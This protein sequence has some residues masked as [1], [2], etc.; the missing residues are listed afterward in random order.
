MTEAGPAPSVAATLRLAARLCRRDL[1]SAP[2]LVIVLA[3]LVAVAAITAVGAFTDRVRLALDAQA[4]ALLAGDLALMSSEPLPAAARDAA[5]AAG[6]ASSEILAM[7]SV[8]AHGKDLQLIELKAVGAGY[9]LR[10]ELL[11]GDA[12]FAPGH[13]AGGIPPRGEAWVEPRLL[14]RL[15][16]A[17]GDELAIGEAR[18]RA[19]KLVLLEPDRAGSFFAI[20]PRVLM[21]LA[22]LPATGLIAPG[23]R[24]QHGLLV[25]GERAAVARF[26]HTVE[27]GPHARWQTP[28]DARPEIRAAMTHAS[29]FLGLAT[30]VATTLSGV[31]I[32]L[33]ARS[34]ARARFDGIALLRTLG[35]TRAQLAWLLGGEFL[36]LG[37]LAAALGTIAG[38]LLQ[39]VLAG[40]LADWTQTALP[41]PSWRP[42]LQGLF[43]GIAAVTGFALAPLL[44][45]REVPPV[46]ILRAEIEPPRTRAASTLLYAAL[47]LGLLAPWGSGDWRLTA[48]AL[49]GFGATLAALALAGHGLLALVA[50]LRRRVG[51]A[52]RA[53]LANLVRRRR[54]SLWQIVA[55][56][57][58]VL[59]LLLLGVLR[60]DLL[61][62][63]RATLPADAPDQ[64][65]IN[66]QQDETRPLAAFLSARGLAGSQLYP[67]YRGRLLAIAGKPIDPDT[68]PDPR[69][70][71]LA[72]REFN[73]STA[74]AL[75]A[76]NRIVA[77]RFWA[78]EAAPQFS[79]ETEIAQTLGIRL[80]DTL[81]FGIADREV[82]ARVTSLREVDWDTMQANFFVLAPPGLLADQP[83][84]YITSFRLP[85]GD[86]TLLPELVARFPSVTVIDVGALF[87]QVRSIMTRATGA[88]EFVFIFTLAAG[89]VV[90]FAAL[91]ATQA[92]RLYDATIMK[93]LGA[94]RRTVAQAIAVE[95]TVL[96]VCA[97]LVGAAGAWG[98]GWLIATRVMRVDYGFDPMLFIAGIALGVG[99]IV[100]V[101]VYAILRALRE[102]VA[103]LLRRV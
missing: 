40:L 14:S 102:P 44:E 39:F 33:A 9:P 48:W 53:G 27:P 1:R 59:A 66:I 80:G 22:D 61:A 46:R 38:Y 12:P 93:T 31:A 28:G 94:S 5:Q 87:G 90:L 100:G 77:G 49:A 63:W 25:A 71:R 58:G 85:P 10:G 76:D 62:Q 83:A 101:G 45:L 37:L 91:Q 64:F 57:L 75:K 69:A 19:T 84:T 20:A 51:I 86:A 29:Q 55:L 11:V 68:Y 52:W 43:G 78:G 47:A 42:A 21:N 70:R 98:T 23:S 60:G 88:V 96:G 73:L 92:E 74:T 50:R 41:P 95:F 17:L 3:A 81:R 79:V 54:H 35:A 2:C 82:E 56:G 36:L 8:V 89:L 34:F 30:L 99:G 15:G 13:R 26:R 7:R 103:N 32:L 97:G 16:L 6:L 65:L 67:M 72:D 24:V 4:S 18:L